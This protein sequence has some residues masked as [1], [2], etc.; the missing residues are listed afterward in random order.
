MA[1]LFLLFFVK[2]NTQYRGVMLRWLHPNWAKFVQVQ[3]Q[4]RPVWELAAE[5]ARRRA[6]YRENQVKILYLGSNRYED[7]VLPL[8]RRQGVDY[9]GAHVTTEP[10]SYLG[11]PVRPTPR[12]AR[13]LKKH[14]WWPGA[15]II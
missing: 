6:T 8:W 7:R 13:P 2:G 14:P 9:D 4:R 5:S 15:M 1:L 10:P 12:C 3:R 11:S